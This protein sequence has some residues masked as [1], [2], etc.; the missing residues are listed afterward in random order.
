MTTRVFTEP[1]CNTPANVTYTSQV[2]TAYFWGLK[3]PLDIKPPCDP[4]FNHLNGVMVKSTIGHYVLT[5][6]TLGIVNKRRVQWCCAPY[7][8]PTD[9]I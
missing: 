9:S 5:T 2:T 6:I 8:P 1:N 3:Q 7:V 4:R